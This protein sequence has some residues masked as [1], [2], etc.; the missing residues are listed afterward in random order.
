M[1]FIG[2]QMSSAM[3]FWGESRMQTYAVQHNRVNVYTQRFMD[4]S[5]FSFFNFGH[6]LNYYSVED[7]PTIHRIV[8]VTGCF[9]KKMLRQ[10]NKSSEEQWVI[11][12]FD[13]TV[14]IIGGYNTIIWGTIILLIGGYQGFKMETSFAKTLYAR[15][16][17]HSP[18]AKS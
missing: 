11:N 18:P 8:P 10:S 17:E 9:L 2:Y 6:V 1:D 3:H 5:D 12:S 4:L 13:Q 15:Q 14:S 7:P 16:D